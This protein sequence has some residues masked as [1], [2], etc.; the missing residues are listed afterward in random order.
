MAGRSSGSSVDEPAEKRRKLAK[1][2][3]L[4]G[5][6]AT[7][8]SAIMKTTREEDI[9][10]LSRWQIGDFI[11]KEFER[12]RCTIELPLEGGGTFPWEVCRADLL[13]KY[14]V[15]VSP[16]FKAALSEAVMSARARPLSAIFYLDE[17]V[18][19]NLLRPDNHRKFWAIYLGIAEF[20]AQRQ[21]QEQFWLP[22]A[23]LRSNIVGSVTGGLSQCFR[24]L[25]RCVLFEPCNLATT[26]AAIQLDGP[27]LLR[28]RASHLIAD[29][30]AIKAVWNSKGAS[31]TK[32]CF[33]CANLVSAMSGLADRP[34][35]IDVSCAD[36][37]AFQ[38][39][40]NDDLWG[41]FD[42]LEQEH[43]RRSKREFVVFQQ[44]FG[45]N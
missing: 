15:E 6:T 32:P 21:W 38:V 12:V 33:F 1:L 19:G 16:A 42:A 9:A 14:F 45:L 30:A 41:A 36:P 23:I 11:K 3:G 8:L 5:V 44:A 35:L 18:P 24:R 34:N 39:M 37:S 25:V 10:P 28:L 31:G 2:V 17:V 40:S 26:G 20:A 7:A 43:G 22:L 4:K 27:T 29:E 13:A